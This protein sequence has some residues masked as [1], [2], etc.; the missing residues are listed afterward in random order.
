MINVCGSA[1]TQ[2][3]VIDDWPQ[4][5]WECSLPC[6]VSDKDTIT[7]YRGDFSVSITLHQGSK[8]I[9]LNSYDILIIL[10]LN[11]YY[12]IGDINEMFKESVA[13]VPQET[14]STELTMCRELLELEPNNKCEKA[15]YSSKCC[16][17]S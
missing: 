15:D 4:V 1:V 7:V 5:M 6:D 16:F 10:G 8:S 12:W 17:A 2:C 9:V 14:L 3:L 11:C 13:M